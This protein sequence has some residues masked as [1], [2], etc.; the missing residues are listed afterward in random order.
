[1]AMF[2]A[3]SVAV[4]FLTMGIRVGHLTFDAKDAIITI[5]AYIY[6]PVPGVLMSFISASIE[7]IISGFETGPIGWIMDILSSATFA[8][9]AAIIYK[10][11]R[12]FNGALISIGCASV[13]MVSLMMLFNMIISPMFFGASP[14][15]P[16]IM[17]D[18]PILYLPFNVAKALMNSAIVMYLY[19]P[20]TLALTKA[21]LLDGEEKAVFSFNKKSVVIIVCG[22]VSIVASV[23]L[24]VLTYFLNKK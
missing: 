19:K 21:K 5:A 20:A 2:V 4:S 22:L 13:V 9:S 8:F 11:K 18:I 7:S 16:G 17:K 24:F 6:G 1:M 10:H 3:L 14:F 12:S 23:G 15:D